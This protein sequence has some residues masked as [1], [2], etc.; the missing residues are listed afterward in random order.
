MMKIN[1]RFLQLS[2]GTSDF[3]SNDHSVKLCL[4]SLA[5]GNDFSLQVMFV[6]TESDVINSKMHFNFQRK[7]NI[8][9]FFSKNLSFL[10]EFLLVQNH[11]TV[12]FHSAILLKLHFDF[13]DRTKI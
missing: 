10:M 4:L 2:Q 12:A 8:Y 7:F 6:V 1:C 11:I 13:S 3:I 9:I 5:A